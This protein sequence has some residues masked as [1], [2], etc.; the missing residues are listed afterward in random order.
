[1]RFRNLHFSGFFAGLLPLL[2]APMSAG[3]DP[4]DTTIQP[5][6]QQSC[7]K[8]HGEKGKMKGKVNLLELTSA[9]HLQEDPELLKDPI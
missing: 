8:C 7:V 4:F 1:M 6:F 9:A 5:A 2:A 3:A